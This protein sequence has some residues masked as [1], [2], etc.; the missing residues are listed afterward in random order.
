MNSMDDTLS[1]G[2]VAQGA[3]DPRIN[4]RVILREKFGAV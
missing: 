1:L 2:D 4:L 3:R